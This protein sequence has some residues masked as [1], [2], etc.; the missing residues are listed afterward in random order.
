MLHRAILGSLERF[1]GM[2]IEHYA[3]RLPAWLAPVQAV[4]ATITN[5][6]DDYA[7]EVASGAAPRPACGSRPTSA[8]DKIG[9]K[10]R[11]HSLHK[12]PLLIAVGGREADG[13]RR[14]ACAASAVTRR[15]PCRLTRP[16]HAV[17][18]RVDAARSVRRR[19]AGAEICRGG[20]ESAWSGRP[21]SRTATGGR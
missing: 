5:E 15:R 21:R 9:Y 7:R 18:A 8:A 10:V 16:W 20:V 4:V 3:G 17:S 14:S 12:V 6:A 1:I 19:L 13:A 2:L 11:E